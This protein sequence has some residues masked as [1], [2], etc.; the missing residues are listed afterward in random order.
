MRSGR[1]AACSI[2][3]VVLRGCWV[4]LLGLGRDRFSD[5]R[6]VVRLLPPQP[7]SPVSNLTCELTQ[8][9]AE[10]RHF[11]TTGSQLTVPFKQI[12]A[13]F[14][15]SPKDVSSLSSSA[16]VLVARIP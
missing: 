11:A 12:F 5:S 15:S 10:A 7:A 6:W 4:C 14:R 1:C 3:S 2:G 8:N 13:T 16:S 9:G